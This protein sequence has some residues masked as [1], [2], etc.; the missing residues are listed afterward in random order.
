MGTVLN[1]YFLIEPVQV[2]L[3]PFATFEELQLLG[4]CEVEEGV[5]EG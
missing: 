3:H 2:G 5:A 1:T 4:V